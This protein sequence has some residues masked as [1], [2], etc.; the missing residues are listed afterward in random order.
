MSSSQERLYKRK[1]RHKN[2]SFENPFGRVPTKTDYANDDSKLPLM[3]VPFYSSE[4]NN[5]REL[6]VYLRFKGID[7]TGHQIDETKWYPVKEVELDPSMSWI[8]IFLSV[9]YNNQ[10]TKHRSSL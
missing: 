9:V 6:S 5:H 10:T 2:H 8:I 1:R 7:N 3:A 4:N